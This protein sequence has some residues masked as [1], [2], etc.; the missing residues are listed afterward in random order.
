M[1]PV[2]L[3][4]LLRHQQEM[5]QQQQ[6]YQQ[7]QMQMQ[8]M[9][10]ATP[11]Q[12][13]AS[14]SGRATKS[15]GARPRRSSSAHA[16]SLPSTVPRTRNDEASQR[17]SAP[18]LGPNPCS[19]SELGLCVHSSNPNKAMLKPCQG[20]CKVRLVHHM[21][22][23]TVE[24]KHGRSGEH[25]GCETV[26]PHCHLL[27]KELRERAQERE[28]EKRKRRR[29][30]ASNRTARP[31]PP[32]P[33]P[34]PPL[35]Q[36]SPQQQR[37][38]PSG[39]EGSARA[40]N[41][42]DSDFDY[43]DIDSEAAFLDD[44]RLSAK[45]HYLDKLATL[46]E[47]DPLKE[48]DLG[49]L[50]TMM[51]GGPP[52]REKA[53]EERIERLKA[54]KLVGTREVQLK[55]RNL[56]DEVTRRYNVLDRLNQEKGVETD[57]LRSF[58]GMKNIDKENWLRTDY[59]AVKSDQ[60]YVFTL[61]EQLLDQLDAEQQNKEREKM[62][63]GDHMRLGT[64]AKLRLIH[65]WLKDSNRDQLIAQFDSM[66]RLQLDARTSVDRPRNI[67]ELMVRWH[68]DG[69]W[70]PTSLA[71]GHMHTK[72]EEPMDLSLDP[73][74]KPPSEEECKNFIAN[75]LSLV[76]KAD[77]DWK[78]S[79]NGQG[80]RV[81]E[82]TRFVVRFTGA[83]YDLEA[84]IDG[85]SNGNTNDDDDHVVEY[86]YKDDDRWDFCKGNLV[87]AYFW[88]ALEHH[89]M[90]PFILQNCERIGLIAGKPASARD[91]ARGM[92]RKKSRSQ[93]DQAMMHM[94]EQL[95]D[96]MERCLSTV[97]SERVEESTVEK[98]KEQINQLNNLLCKRQAY[99]AA[100]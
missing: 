15:T 17:K 23:I 25:H 69:S 66:T 20:G 73:S 98:L 47:K 80:N 37:E 9:P 91:A 41:D 7:Q 87:L 28:K 16:G 100:W 48:Y 81:E 33:P 86:E 26:C 93:R 58:S 43:A 56:D 36:Q 96:M 3:D 24:E 53:I 11:F 4:V 64:K 14:A 62:A 34:P 92:T 44:E 32:P 52:L 72:F 77:A 59:L 61:L 99:H 76:K 38:D 67:W 50:R 95:P 63:S 10:A 71:L 84:G 57:K 55:Q 27:I 94:M 97:L 68:L 29:S 12:L 18:S 88:G 60:R 49:I 82:G 30:A 22:Q 79:G 2:R 13:N 74:S 46:Q 83:E 70:L 78:Q 8:M 65:A 85:V 31:P 19:W 21:C 6:L 45:H 40:T 89:Q 1:Q 35:P 39:D 42:G 90:V 75:L 51:I 5:Q 54:K